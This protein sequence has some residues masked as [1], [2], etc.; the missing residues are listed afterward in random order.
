VEKSRD[1]IVRKQIEFV[2][3]TVRHI[4]LNKLSTLQ[5]TTTI[6]SSLNSL[7]FNDTH[8]PTSQKIRPH[9]FTTK[10]VENHKHHVSVCTTNDEGAPV[11][12]LSPG[13]NSHKIYTFR[14]LL[15]EAPIQR[16]RQALTMNIIPWDEPGESNGAGGDDRFGSSK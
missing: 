12:Q 6:S 2:F 1:S 5:P 16:F 13:N 7:K 14:L 4:W 3:V 15:T 8:H 10:T 9:T 11:F